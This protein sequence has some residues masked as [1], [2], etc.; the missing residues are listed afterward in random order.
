MTERMTIKRFCE[1]FP[2][3]EAAKI[4]SGLRRLDQLPKGDESTDWE[5]RVEF[6]DADGTPLDVTTVCVYSRAQHGSSSHVRP[7]LVLDNNEHTADLPH[8]PAT[9]VDQAEGI[10]NDVRIFIQLV[11]SLER[12]ESFGFVGLK[13]VREKHL[14]DTRFSCSATPQARGAFM[15]R[16]TSEGIV[17]TYNV[18]NPANPLRP[19]TAI[20]LNRANASVA[21]VLGL[22]RD[23]SAASSD[24]T[25]RRLIQ[26]KGAPL[27]QTIM[28]ERR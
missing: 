14:A 23:L 6:E 28:D 24:A 5:I 3:S 16:M 27:S 2:K 4:L 19:V 1:T 20:R 26:V 17:T 9:K 12:N 7:P 15:R 10:P 13:F 11:D 8:V 21:E 22:P 25:P 18:E